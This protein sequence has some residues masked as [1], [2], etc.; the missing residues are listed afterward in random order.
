MKNIRLEKYLYSLLSDVSFSAE[1]CNVHEKYNLTYYSLFA[2]L[3]FLLLICSEFRL[4]NFCMYRFF[5]TFS[6][7]DYL[8]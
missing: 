7:I 1:W 8:S 3:D 2:K 6:T 5:T 4:R